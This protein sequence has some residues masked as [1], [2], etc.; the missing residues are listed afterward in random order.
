MFSVSPKGRIRHLVT[1]CVIRRTVPFA[2]VRNSG[3]FFPHISW[4]SSR[5]DA[6]APVFKKNKRQSLLCLRS[7]TQEKFAIL[8]NNNTVIIIIIVVVIIIIIII[9]II[10]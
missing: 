3:S 7:K 1:L 8:M 6:K 5:V 2:M 10:K 4:K 9:I